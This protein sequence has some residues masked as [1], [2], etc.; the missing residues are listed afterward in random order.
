MHL[1]KVANKAAAALVAG[2][3]S[4][5]VPQVGAL[6]SPPA[7]AAPARVSDRLGSASS[8]A[9]GP[10]HS[11]RAA[12]LYPR[13]VPAPV[14]ET[15]IIQGD[16]AP[17]LPGLTVDYLGGSHI[18]AAGNILCGAWLDG[19]GV[20]PDNDMVLFFGQPGSL[21]PFLRE[22]QQAPQMP[23]GIVI[24]D[25][26]YSREKVCETGWIALTTRI[27]GPGI[28][29]WFNDCVLYVGPPDDL[30]PVL[31]GADQAPQCEPGVYIDVSS[32]TGNLGGNL[33]D[34]GTLLVSAYLH[35][36]GI[37]VLNDRV[38]YIGTHE[39]SSPDYVLSLAYR[40]GMQASACPEGVLF[41]Y[42]TFTAHNDL[43]PDRVRRRLARDGRHQREQPWPLARD[44]WSAEQSQPQRRSG[45]VPRA[46]NYLEGRWRGRDRS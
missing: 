40:D 30:R 39:G 4:L 35:G 25:L 7:R 41:D 31:K 28:T 8:D 43:G 20:T 16:P 21:V 13:P 19:P 9:K 26:Y 42:A 18:D 22:G 14:I 29:P 23:A 3:V 32:L 46:G 36:P 2:A 27:S 15:V 45:R 5:A 10:T 24:S 1:R 17:G 34:N 11:P 44:G 38:C 37:T 12:H 33:S 6:A